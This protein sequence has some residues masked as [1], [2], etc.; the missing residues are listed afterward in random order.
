MER[1]SSYLQGRNIKNENN[2][3]NR[4][5]HRDDNRLTKDTS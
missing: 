1:R 5:Q 4:R 3:G 2:K